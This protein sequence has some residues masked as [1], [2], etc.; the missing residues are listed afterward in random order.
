MLNKKLQADHW[1]EMCYQ[2]LKLMTKQEKA[3]KD[4][5][6]W[7]QQ[8]NVVKLKKRSVW[9]VTVDK[10]DSWGWKCLLSF[11]EW[12]GG[13]IKHKI[14]DGKSISVWHDNWN[15]WVSL[16]IK[17]S[18]KEIF[19]AGFKDQDTI[20]DVLNENG[21]KWPQSWLVKYPWLANIQNLRLNN[22]PDKAVWI[23]NNGTKRNFSTNIV[24]KDVRENSRKLAAKKKLCTQDKLVKW[25]LNKSF[26]CSLCKKVPDSH[27]HLFFGC[28]YAQKFWKM[29]CNIANLKLKEEKWDKILEEISR[30]NDN[31]SICGVIRKLCLAA[32]V[33][34]IWEARNLRLFNNHKRDEK[35]LFN[36]MCEDLRDKIVL[37]KVKNSKNVL[38]AEAVWNV[39]CEVVAAVGYGRVYGSGNV[40]QVGCL[41][42]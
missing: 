4:L 37:I 26:E 9:D 2:L 15:N 14:G 31:R 5:F 34:F 38:Q 33:Y 35:E 11:R 20:Q 40:V 19:Y 42:A 25:C 29:V 30:G 8:I 27:D 6:K 3:K 17:I 24:W 21:W 7:D 10:T 32:G 36:I 16:S 18:K 39:N 12:I 1:N 22:N 28:D 41:L 13:H 23:D